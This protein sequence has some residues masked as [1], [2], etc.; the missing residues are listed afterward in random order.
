[1]A[2]TS[3]ATTFVAGV[4][5]SARTNSLARV[6]RTTPFAAN[7]NGPIQTGTVYV[8]GEI[9]PSVAV[10]PRNHRNQ[11]VAYQQDR[12]SNG[13]ANGVLTA[14]TFDTGRSWRVL[15]LRK[16]P[17]FSRCT[18]GTRANGGDFER[19]SDVWVS[20]GPTGVA[21][22]AAVGFN[23]SNAETAEL[24]A[25]STDGG[26][27]WSRPTT[28]IRDNDPAVADERP[29]ITADPTNS[30]YAY[31]VWDRDVSAPPGMRSG[32]TFFSRTTD[33]GQT[34][35]SARTIYAPPVGEQTSGNQIVVL[36]G[37]DLVNVFN[38]FAVNGQSLHPRHDGIYAIRSSDKGRTWSRPTL[39]ARSF[40]V[41]VTDPH[42]GQTVREGD[43]FTAI[44]ADPRRG[45][46]TLYAVW[47]DARFTDGQRHQIAF[48][49]ST[50]AGRTWSTPTRVSANLRTQAFVP[51][52]AVDDIGNVAVTYYDLS[53]DR[54]TSAPLPT[55]YWFTR[56]SN[57]GRSW[58]ARR[59]VTMR[60][61]DLRTAPFSGGYFLGEY[62]GLTS[63]GRSFTLAATFTND[64]SLVN[65][66]DIFAIT[67]RP[68]H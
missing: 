26:R 48:A 30:K 39:V 20:F 6:S 55:Q 45:S 28:L 4:P 15:P 29:A 31:V 3:S 64:R 60:P 58:S 67:Y 25:R 24:V 10:N 42:S 14:V 68:R 1:M 57:G 51:A 17:K 47:E 35:Q 56:S 18:G 16:Q 62:Q 27:S 54:A 11:I 41:G 65:R 52:V 43:I 61:F 33:R 49:R 2:Q 66:T 50:N 32:P 8:N 23:D 5:T 19:T 53:A 21:Y 36:P 22:Q 37:G 13:G 7:C 34:W 40:V 59:Q 38:V 63:A 44:A 46:N 12:Y 9:E